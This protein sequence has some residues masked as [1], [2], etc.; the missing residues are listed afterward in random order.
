MPLRR[1]S[2]HRFQIGGPHIAARTQTAL[3]YH[4]NAERCKN[5]RRTCFESACDKVLIAREPYGMGHLGHRRS[6]TMVRLS[7]SSYENVACSQIE[8]A[9]FT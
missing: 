8:T 5:L 6:A 1:C 4:T 3:E 2:P 7:L 9:L